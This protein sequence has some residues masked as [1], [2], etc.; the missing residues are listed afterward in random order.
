MQFRSGLQDMDVWVECPCV[1]SDRIERAFKASQITEEFQQKTFDNFRIQGRPPIVQQALNFS[2]VYAQNFGEIR[3]ER[4]NSLCML[5]RPGCGK[6]HLLMAVSN[7][8]LNEGKQVLYFPWVEG[9]NELKDNLDTLETRISKLQRAEVL[10]IDDLFK[11][12]KEPTDF[13]REQAFAIINY[14]YMERKPIL[15]SSEWDIDRMCDFDEAIG[16]RVAEMCRNFKIEL[17]G[18]RELNYRL[19]EGL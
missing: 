2:K 15:V 9:F 10:F 4:S 19:V 16:S 5:G 11:G 13:Q 3:K 8:L 12:R 14:R 18:G 1:E 17:K 7:H 6:T